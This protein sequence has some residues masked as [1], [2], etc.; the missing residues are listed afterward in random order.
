[1]T[2]KELTKQEFE[3]SIKQIMEYMRKNY[4]PHVTIIM[5]CTVCEIVEGMQVIQ[6]EKFEKNMEQTK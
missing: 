1:M 6:N 5:H 3:Q 4:H 2:I